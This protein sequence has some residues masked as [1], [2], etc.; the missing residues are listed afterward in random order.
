MKKI[1]IK[2]KTLRVLNL[3]MYELIAEGWCVTK[4]PKKNFWGRWVVVMEKA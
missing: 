2:S 1:K 3:K 4:E